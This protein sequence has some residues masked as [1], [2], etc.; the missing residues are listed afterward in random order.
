MDHILLFTSKQGLTVFSSWGLI[1]DQK[2]DT[3]MALSN[4]MTQIERKANY[5]VSRSYL[6]KFKQYENNCI[7]EFVSPC[8]V[9]IQKCD[10]I[11]N[12]FPKMITEH[13][14][15]GKN[16][17][18]RTSTSYGEDVRSVSRMQWNEVKF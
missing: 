9:H 14:F 12:E 11:E 13:F 5:R 2:K 6:Q 4:F 1:A 15:A 10:F 16:C 8:K 17:N 18:S 3:D 7:K